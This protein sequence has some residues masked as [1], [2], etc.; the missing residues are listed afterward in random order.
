MKTLMLDWN[1]HTRLPYRCTLAPSAMNDRR[2]V[3]LDSGAGSAPLLVRY[4]FSVLMPKAP[5]VAHSSLFVDLLSVRV[6]NE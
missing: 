4:T 3:A 5:F 6:F 1:D 2:F